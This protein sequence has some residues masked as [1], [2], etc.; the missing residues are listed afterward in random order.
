VGSDAQGRETVPLGRKILKV[1]THRVAR[2]VCPVGGGK[3]AVS[4]SGAGMV[5]ANDR[6]VGRP[7][8]SG[9]V[10]DQPADC[11]VGI[12]CIGI[13]NRRRS[14]PACW[15]NSQYSGLTPATV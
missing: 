4:L 6:G 12:R 1:L 2:P 10:N 11:M 7:A 13:N 5:W 14:S 3:S 15:P 8:S 9:R